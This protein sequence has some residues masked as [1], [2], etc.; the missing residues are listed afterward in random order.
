MH[1]EC[2]EQIKVN[3]FK[4]E[5]IKILIYKSTKFAQGKDHDLEQSRR[6][7]EESSKEIS[8]QSRANTLLEKRLAKITEDL[9]CVKSNLSTT[10]TTHADQQA[11]QKQQ[12]GFAEKQLKLLGQQRNGLVAAYKRQLLLLD[13]LKRQNMCLQQAQLLEFVEQ[14]FMKVLDWNQH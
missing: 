12:L 8:Q 2:V 9:D 5:N 1:S 10:K 3:Q 4:G 6:K 7:L 14:D 11:A 13:N